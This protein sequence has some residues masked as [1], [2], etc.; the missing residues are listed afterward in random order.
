MQEREPSARNS[1]GLTLL[2]LAVC[3]AWKLM[4]GE[5]LEDR[6]GFMMIL[7]IVMQDKV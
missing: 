1:A 6:E 3:T 2:D 4:C 7:S 5:V